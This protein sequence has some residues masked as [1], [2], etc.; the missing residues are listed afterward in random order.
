MEDNLNLL[1][2]AS[3]EFV[4]AQPQLVKVYSSINLLHDFL[5]QIAAEVFL[6]NSIWKL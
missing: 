2:P 1:A 5:P 6:E 3:P 4:T